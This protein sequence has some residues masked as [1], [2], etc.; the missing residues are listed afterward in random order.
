MLCPICG[1]CLVEHEVQQ[2]WLF[3]C[4]GR[5]N[6]HVFE[7]PKDKPSSSKLELLLGGMPTYVG[8]DS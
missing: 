4:E 7:V 1:S 8:S 5:P 2:R 3:Q 6:D